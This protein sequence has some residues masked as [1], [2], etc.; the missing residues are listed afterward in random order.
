MSPR[1][2]RS[3][4]VTSVGAYADS[5]FGTGGLTCVEEGQARV[6]DKIDSTA[7]W[8]GSG[9]I[10]RFARGLQ[11][12]VGYGPEGMRSVLRLPDARDVHDVV[13]REGQFVCVSTGT[14]E[15]LWI[16]PFGRVTRRWA[17]PGDRD[18][19]HLNCLCEKD[20]R[21][22][23]S[24][25]G[26]FDGHREWVGKSQGRG[27]IMDLETGETVV[28]NLSGPHNPRFIDG[29]WVVCDSHASA[30]VLQDAA[31]RR[32][33]VALEGF[34]RGLA[35]DSHFFYV[36]ESA[37]RKEALP[38]G[39]SNIAI[40]ERQSLEVVG[41]VRIPFPEIYEVVLLPAAEGW[42]FG[43]APE[44]FEVDRGGERLRA[45]ESQVELGLRE[46]ATLR[47][48]LDDVETYRQIKA[49]MTRLKRRIL[50]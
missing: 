42:R 25:F 3:L 8:A 28:E 30:L 14:N 45:L 48:C 26:R 6:I 41:R 35:H 18:A 13:L 37:S 2:H 20:G 27:F 16:D 34:T 5:G 40:I 11:S 31:G 47:F 12:I 39:H 32:R 19:W 33:V 23:L 4:L 50:G 17:A 10:W 46:I 43:S 7:L 1:P 9:M 38:S 22:F 36:G 49:G 44:A 21:L 29:Q 15:V 24:A